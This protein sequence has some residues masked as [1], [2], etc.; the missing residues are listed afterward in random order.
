MP[1]LQFVD[2][3]ADEKTRKWLELLAENMKKRET[4]IPKVKVDADTEK[5]IELKPEL[6][7]RK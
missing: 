2:R 1:K 7:P 4:K 5:L 6:R 3:V